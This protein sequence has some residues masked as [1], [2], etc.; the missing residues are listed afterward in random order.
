MF[1]LSSLLIAVASFFAGSIDAIVGGGGLILV[2]ALFATYPT[3]SPATLLGTNKCASVWGTSLATYQYSKRVQM[4]WRA[5]LPAALFALAGSFM[6]AWSVTLIDP[7]FIRKLMPLILLVVLIYTLVKKDLGITHK[8]HHNKNRER[9]I[10]CL[11]GA[12]IGWYDGFFGPGTGSFFIFLFVRFLGYD[13]L[14]ASASAKLLNVATNIAAILLFALKGHVWW[15]IGLMMAV[16]NMAGSFI[17]SHLALKHGTGF[18]RW[19]FVLVVSL[20]II[21]TGLAAF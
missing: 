21:K 13:F 16:T 10:A 14:N 6:G 1:D 7:A 8:P 2:P 9:I 12:V 15:H 17:G 4:A 5:L 3:A 18:V 11:I 19:V 20:L